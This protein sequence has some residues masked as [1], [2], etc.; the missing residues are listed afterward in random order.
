MENIKAIQGTGVINTGTTNKVS[1]DIDFKKLLVDALEK[2]NQDQ[3]NA[4]KMDQQF[5]LGEID[6]IHDVMI[7]SQKAEVSLTFAVEVRNK[8]VEA[9]KEIMRIQM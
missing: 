1:N 7:A 8:I 9:Y 4:E 6:N 2:V 5:M 3:L